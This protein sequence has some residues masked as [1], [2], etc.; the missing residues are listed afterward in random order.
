[1]LNFFYLN[2]FLFLSGGFDFL[3]GE[4]KEFVSVSLR[5]KELSLL[6]GNN[7]INL[8]SEKRPTLD[9]NPEK[10]SIKDIISGF[11]YYGDANIFL[12]QLSQMEIP[13]NVSERNLF[14]SN[15]SFQPFLKCK[16]IINGSVNKLDVT[17]FKKTTKNSKQ[18][19]SKKDNEDK[20]D[21]INGIEI[22][23]LTSPE[24]NDF[25]QIIERAKLS[26]SP[27]LIHESPLAC[28]LLASYL[29]GY[30]KWSVAKALR[31][32]IRS[33]HPKIPQF[34]ISV[35][36]DILHFEKSF[37]SYSP[38]I[39]LQSLILHET[40][41]EDLDISV[42]FYE[43]G[44]I[45]LLKY[46]ER[47]SK[48]FKYLKS[49]KK[50]KAMKLLEISP[51]LIYSRD[52]PQDCTPLH[53]M[54]NNQYFNMKEKTS[55]KLLSKLASSNCVNLCDIDGA[56]PLHSAAKLAAEHCIRALLEV[57]ASISHVCYSSGTLPLHEATKANCSASVIEDLI[58][59]ENLN[60]TDLL[61]FTAL[62]LASSN[63][64]KTV[65]NLLLSKGAAVLSNAL[66]QTPM[67]L[68]KNDPKLLQ[69]LMEDARPGG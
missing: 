44:N 36:C 21:I 2:L 48:L 65:M 18:K 25:F 61:G 60:F 46:R 1:M 40:G 30:R 14:F 55:I 66:G 69:L 58:N 62:H 45:P 15:P 64:N 38:S 53:Y 50:T 22:I 39:K 54:V 41:D 11:I 16:I 27:V 24:K 23:H 8:Y 33:V 19:K 51:D 28:S 26:C 56:T 47:S 43:S 7:D 68:T 20:D 57:N 37:L 31:H 13:E 34:D 29:V 5:N 32:I 49:G 12:N 63:G 67:H 9:I 59:P 42:A 52:G 3:V 6:E 4:N 35:I 10:E 17:K